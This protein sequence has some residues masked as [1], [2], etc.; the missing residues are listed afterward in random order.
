MD[1]TLFQEIF[2]DFLPT[3]KYKIYCFSRS[4]HKM[5]SIGYLNG[6]KSLQKKIDISKDQKN[7]IVNKKI[8]PNYV[9][10]FISESMVAESW[11][12]QKIGTT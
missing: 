12:F 2:C 3:K 9:I 7:F 1:Q 8:K 4:S 11:I 5:N 10:N 6:K